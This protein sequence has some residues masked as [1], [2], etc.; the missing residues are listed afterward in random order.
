MVAKAVNTV[1]RNT[2]AGRPTASST[3]GGVT[4]TANRAADG[5][6]TTITSTSH[7]GDWVLESQRAD[8]DADEGEDDDEEGD[9]SES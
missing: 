2:L 4:A 6:G 8:A 3:A 5:A 1:V 7:A 9:D